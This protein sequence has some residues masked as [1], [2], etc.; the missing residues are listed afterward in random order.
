MWKV[1]AAL[2]DQNKWLHEFSNDVYFVGVF[3]FKRLLEV[4]FF[5]K[6]SAFC[7]N[8]FIW[9]D[10]KSAALRRW[11]KKVNCIYSRWQETDVFREKKAPHCFKKKSCHVVK[12]SS[13]VLYSGTVLQQHQCRIGQGGWGHC[14]ATLARA[15]IM[16]R[17][18]CCLLYSTW[19]VTSWIISKLRI[20]NVSEQLG[21]TW[22]CTTAAE[23]INIYFSLK[24][25]GPIS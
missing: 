20:R 4:D 21:V 16:H 15:V 1:T 18:I 10:F 11:N 7:L 6:S 3:C 24:L 2:N 14:C 22:S 8:C 5:F 13:R 23:R 12:I 17:H 19:L 9:N 25:P